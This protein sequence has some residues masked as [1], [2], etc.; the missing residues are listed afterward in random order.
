MRREHLATLYCQFKGE[1]W[2]VDVF[3]NHDGTFEI[4]GRST[5][6]NVYLVNTAH[7]YLVAVTNHS[8]CG[9]VPGDVNYMDVMEYVDVENPIDAATLSIGLRYLIRNNFRSEMNS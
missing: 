3:A 6:F 8:R 1:T 9:Y 7:G 2:E 5:S 4:T